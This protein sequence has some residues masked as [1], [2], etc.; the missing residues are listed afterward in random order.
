MGDNAKDD[1]RGKVRLKLFARTVQNVNTA[2]P[3]QPID[4]LIDMWDLHFN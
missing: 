4:E 3:S 2:I 1:D